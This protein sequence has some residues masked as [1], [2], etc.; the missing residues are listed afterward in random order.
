MRLLPTSCQL[1]P[2]NVP[3]MNKASA[4]AVQPQPPLVKVPEGSHLAFAE[5][6][7]Y[8]DLLGQPGGSG[9]L[10]LQT[11]LAEV[12]QGGSGAALGSHYCCVAP[13]P[14]FHLR[15]PGLMVSHATPRSPLP[16]PSS[17]TE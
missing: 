7:L 16:G 13:L 5:D 4:A 10:L 1:F 9:S 2:N 6:D 12:R 3:L 11:Q 15:C 14:S 17:K 8:G